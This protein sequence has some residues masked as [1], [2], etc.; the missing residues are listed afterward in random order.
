MI[1]ADTGI[2]RNGFFFHYCHKNKTMMALQVRWE[3]CPFC[4]Q[5]NPDYIRPTKV[6][7][8]ISNIPTGS[9]VMSFA[10]QRKAIDYIC[11]HPE[12]QFALGD[13]GYVE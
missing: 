6:I 9:Q 5:K 12:E 11:N 3:K 8:T 7:Y 10:D 2:V 1:S 13:T 4:Y